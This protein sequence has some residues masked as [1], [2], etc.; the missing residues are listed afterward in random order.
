MDA[1][2]AIFKRYCV[3]SYKDRAVPD[4]AIERMLNAAV[5]APSAGN[6][7]SWRFVVVKD[8]GLK[9]DL[10]GAAGQRFVSRCSHLIV[11]CADLETAESRYGRRGRELYC[12]QD[13]AAAMQN[14]FLA[15][16]VEG[17][18]ACWV[19]AFDEGEVARVLGLP[20]RFR[21]VAMMPVGYPGRMGERR[22]RRP[23]GE[24]VEW[25]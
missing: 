17:L 24:V 11:V 7:Q 5:A 6:L 3:R 1:Y 19:G 13:T 23:L 2:E 8:P 14:L 9:E 22:P 20:S 10:A 12:L 4:D 15:A 16:T 18:A 21:P 25:R